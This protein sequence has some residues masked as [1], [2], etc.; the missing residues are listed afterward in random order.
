MDLSI[1][2]INRDSLDVTDFSMYFTCSFKSTHTRK[3]KEFF[4]VNRT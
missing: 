2:V 3:N 1:R 4:F